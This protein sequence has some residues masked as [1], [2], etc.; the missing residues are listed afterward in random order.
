M[1]FSVRPLSFISGGNRFE[2]SITSASRNG[3]LPS[4]E[5]AIN[6]LSPCDE[7]RYPERSVVISRY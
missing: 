2:N 6:I 4:T 5:W 1:R 7:I 3:N